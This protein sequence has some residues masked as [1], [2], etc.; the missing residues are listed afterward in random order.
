MAH[1]KQNELGDALYSAKQAAE[2]YFKPFDEYER[3]ESNQPSPQ[4]PDQYPRITDGTLSS[5]HAERPMRIWGQLQTGRVVQLPTDAQDFAEWKLEMLNIFWANRIVKNANQQAPFFIKLRTALAKA[6]TYGSHPVFSFPVNT[7]YYTGADFILPRVRDI[8]LEPG[9]TSDLDSDYIWLNRHYTKLQLRGIIQS[10][11]KQKGH[12]GWIL[13]ELKE[14]Y[15]SEAFSGNNESKHSQDT[16]KTNHSKTVTFSTCFHRGNNAPFYTIYRDGGDTKVIRTTY[17]TNATGDVP[18]NLLYSEYDLV[19]PY[20]VSQIERAGP[21]QNMLDFMVSAHALSVQQ[22]LDPPIIISGNAENDSGFDIDSLVN[23]SGALWFTGNATVKPADMTTSGQAR[24]VESMGM[25][26]TNIMN[27]QGTT[28]ATVSGTVSGNPMY[29]KTPTGIK[30]QQERTNARDNALRQNTDMFMA[31]LA[32]NLINITINNVDGS[33]IIRIT[34]DQR[35]KLVA[36]GAKIPDGAM[37]IVAEFEELR[38]GEFDFDVEPGSSV[39]KND[40]ETKDRV[41]EAIKTLTEVPDLDNRLAQEGKELKLSELIGSYLATSG[42]ENYEKVVV[43]LSDEKKA[44][45]MQAN[46]EDVSVLVEQAL[47]PVEDQAY[48]QPAIDEQAERMKVIEA[49]RDEGW[50]DE[51]IAQYLEHE[52]SV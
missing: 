27:Q 15:D 52:G 19:N 30:Q 14:I 3:L 43:E 29:S 21:T 24:F 41:L 42:L 34:E 20:G 49:L 28:D 50:S 23:A 4:L 36:K 22:A 48:V 6:G 13:R 46:A 39:I 35:D 44:M 16:D 12:A 8:Y 37:E 38:D 47:P 45:L 40:S 31:A 18:I 2:E 25:Y 33:E 7:P 51:Q 17:N 11:A 5:L 9:K 10:A 32:R 26:K 1:L